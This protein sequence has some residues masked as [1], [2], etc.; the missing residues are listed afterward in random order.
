MQIVALR[1][2]SRIAPRVRMDAGLDVDALSRDPE[3]IRRY[4]EDPLVD[5]RITVALARAMTE[6]AART[7]HGG[8]E[9][10]LPV[11]VLHGDHHEYTVDRPLVRHTTGRRLENLTRLQVPGSPDVGWVRV[12][13]TPGVADPFVFEERLIPRWKYW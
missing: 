1:L 8:A 10:A 12:V 5:T 2:L 4:L 11:L 13:V 7:L 3:V 9:V 6:A